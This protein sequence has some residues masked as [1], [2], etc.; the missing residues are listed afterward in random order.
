MDD[1]TLGRRATQLVGDALR[2]SRVVLLHGP[3]Q[4][5][6]STVGQLLAAAHAMDYVTF[7]DA[8]QLSAA[9][10][11]PVTFLSNFARP[12]IIDEVQR[13]GS[14]FVIAI[15]AVVDRT[16][17]PGRY[18]VM[19][20]TNFLTVPNL[21]ESLTGRIRIV[22]LWPFSYGERLSGSDSFVDRAFGGAKKLMAHAGALVERDVYVRRACEG[23]FPGAI[24]LD[25]R[26]RM[27]WFHDYIDTVVQ[28]EIAEAADIRQVSGLRRLAQYFA[29]NSGGELVVSKIASDLGLDRSTV[30]SYLG[31][32]ETAFIVH[33][34]SAWSRNLTAKVVRRPKIFVS[35]SGLAAAMMGKGFAAL[36]A[37]T[38]VKIGAVVETMVVCELSKQL[39]WSDTTAELGHLRDSDGREVDAILESRDGRVVGI[40]VKST[41]TPKLEHFR[42][43]ADLRDRLDRAGG[44]FV[45][46]VLFYTGKARLSFGDRLVAL[47]LG[48]LWT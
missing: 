13:A 33:R 21:A 41:S 16:R 6:K 32:L 4:S 24:D 22:R 14:A 30:E 2:V 46:G 11:D 37:L 8:A 10:A 7:D 3:R 44:I 47:P 9:Q 36:R 39:T 28:R 29:A 45:V 35:D 1:T 18:L 38:E 15:K 23:G 5:G 40:E 19:G 12:L 42:W 20:S 34:V 31:W 17:K 27:H 48:D 43:L 25:E 26:D